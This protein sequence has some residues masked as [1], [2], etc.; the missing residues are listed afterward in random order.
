MT[1]V[2]RIDS[3]PGA[4]KPDPELAGKAQFG[5]YS[6][7]TNRDGGD[8]S[9]STRFNFK[10]ADLKFRISS[11]HNLEII[12]GTYAVFSG[13]GTINKLNAPGGSPYQIMVWAGDGQPDTLRVRIWYEVGTIDVVVYDN[14]Y[15]QP[16]AGGYIYIGTE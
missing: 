10:A 6:T 15:D 2:G 11:F 9:G 7:N 12:G 5:F 8:P 14:G 4:F 13:E 3:P 1:G 16:L